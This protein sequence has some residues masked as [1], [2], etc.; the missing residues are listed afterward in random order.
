M[1][2]R[3]NNRLSSGKFGT[4]SS[5]KIYRAAR[6]HE[7]YFKWRQKRPLGEKSTVESDIPVK[8]ANTRS[9]AVCILQLQQK[10]TIAFSSIQR[11]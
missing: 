3:F 4:V 8:R 10:V 6:L 5:R 9:A 7:G 2:L 1:S 11:L